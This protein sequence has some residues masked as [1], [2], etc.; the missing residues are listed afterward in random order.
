ME[1]TIASF[2]SNNAQY[3]FPAFLSFDKRLIEII[4]LYSIKAI[5]FSD[6][7]SLICPVYESKDFFSE[8]E[9][10]QYFSKEYEIKRYTERNKDINFDK[11]IA[12]LETSL[13]K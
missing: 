3:F 4:K 9:V 11:M 5:G 10:Q 13:C 6:K 1:R 2:P 12:D 7:D 8:T